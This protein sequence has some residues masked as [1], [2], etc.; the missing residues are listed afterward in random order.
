MKLTLLT[1]V[2]TGTFCSAVTVRVGD[3][4]RGITLNSGEPLAAGTGYIAAGYFSTDLTF[5]DNTMFTPQEQAALVSSF[6]QWGDAGTSGQGASNV[7]GFFQFNADGGRV[8][9]AD[10]ALGR[11]IVVVIGNGSSIAESTEL[12]VFQAASSFTDD[13]NTPTPANPAVP[14]PANALL[15]FDQGARASNL[16]TLSLA[17]VVPEPSSSL[18]AGL[19]L[20]GA[21]A[22]RRRN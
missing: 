22:R 18:L 14:V 1:L 12:A 17:S 16:P 13:S 11:S 10:A 20:V 21:L 19:A 6:V 9:A 4:S 15:G 3:F 5:G 2:A 7:P 8:G